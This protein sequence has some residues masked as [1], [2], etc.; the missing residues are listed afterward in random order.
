[1]FK[2][3][4]LV[5][6]RA[7][8]K[9]KSYI[10]INTLGL[11]IALACCIAAYLIL[12]FNIEFDSFHADKKVERIFKIHTH[13]QE[14]DGKKVQNNNAPMVLAPHAAP[15]V[16]GIER[17][18]RYISD[19]G[20]MRNG[21]KAFTQ[22]ISFADS[23]FFDMFDFPLVQGDHKSFKDKYSIFLQEETAKKYF[24]DEPALGKMLVL[25]FANNFE[26]Q[27]VVGGVLKKMPVNNSFYFEAMMRIENLQDIHKLALD[28]W[29]D[30]R[31]PSTFMEISSPENAATI[32]K[33][34]SKYVPIRNEA[35]KDNP[36]EFYQ[37]EPFKSKFT[38]DDIGWGYANM[39]MGSL[40]PIVFTAMAGLILLIACFN[41]TNTS[42]AITAKRLKEVGIR[43]AVGAMRQQIIFQFLL[44]TIMTITLSL[45]VGLLIAQWL[46]PVFTTMWDLPY[47][48][49]DLSGVNL[50]ISLMMLVFF[51][52]LLA[53][54]YPALFNSKFKPVALLKGEVKIK[55]TNALTRTLVSFQFA[56]SVI[57]LIAGV[58]FTQNSKFQEQIKFGYDKD[59][60]ITVRIQSESE[61]ETME[62]AITANPK[63]LE[64]SVSDHH[65]G[66][67]SYQFPF[68]V[69]TAEYTA[70]LIG[71]GKNYFET[72]GF[73]LKEGRFPNLENATERN[74][75]VIVNQALLDK[76]NMTNPIDKI[77]TVH[78]K[79]RHIVGVVDNHVDNLF[80]SKE[81]EP[82]IFYPADSSEFKMI[83]VRTEAQDL[84]ET[85][86]YLETTWKK[87]FPGKPFEGQFQEDIL[88]KETKN[89]NAN[90]KNIFL[91]LT[92]LGG[93]LS[94]SGIFSLASL[95][96]A[97][98]TKEIGIRK[99]L[100]AT[101][102]N[103][104]TLLNKEFVIILTISGIL[105]SVG[106]FY[107]VDL[108]LT[109]IYAYHIP[110]GVFPVVI[111]AV[112]IFVIGIFTTSMTIL[113]AAKAN[114]VK[115]LRSE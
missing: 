114:P 85:K 74:E 76:I 115:T 86:T 46:V 5:A 43:K 6:F 69:D 12:A 32:S 23:T 57:V 98:R 71:V 42:I 110:V 37:L 2:N 92:V 7:L 36:V 97:K 47:S 28:D 54:I 62:N 83:Q 1:M 14:K 38:Q 51:A 55:G 79:K 33:Q 109:Q 80:R 63:I 67:S 103:V 90:L 26:I 56:L 52:S 87:I 75:S 99:A 34:F 16:A 48:L 35:K 13:L 89:V 31:D 29:G 94:A 60:I 10:I 106:G 81:A 78:E 49:S 11:G 112:I 72:V 91:F 18:T 4:L 22:G 41:L 58:L 111:C 40:A 96:I 53:G 9:N 70:Q 65:V 39:R 17:F 101:V 84:A 20:Y 3:Y 21:D 8:K 19:G 66:Y 102:S 61:F 113:K 27:V 68:K 24:G 104:V 30:W 88:L 108:L 107:L 59:M 93:L 44:E 25:N 95:N 105:G 64:V 15:E 82:F 100:G 50:F 45:A 73:T 77:I